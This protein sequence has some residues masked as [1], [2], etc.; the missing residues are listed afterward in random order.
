MTDISEANAPLFDT[1][2]ESLLDPRT[3]PNEH[4][5]SFVGVVTIALLVAALAAAALALVLLDPRPTASAG[6]SPAELAILRPGTIPVDDQGR[7]V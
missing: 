6:A 2:S 7:Q 4:K 5:R 1:S 3:A